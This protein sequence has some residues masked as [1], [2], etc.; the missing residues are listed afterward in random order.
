MFVKVKP[1]LGHSEGASAL[2][3]IIKSVVSLECRTILPN[4]KFKQ[5]NPRFMF[6]ARTREIE[7]IRGY[8]TRTDNEDGSFSSIQIGKLTSAH[9]TN[10]LAHWPS[11]ESEHK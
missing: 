8:Q 3:S 11:G 7:T 6:R 2:T 9:L 4:I 10:S 1:N 5:P